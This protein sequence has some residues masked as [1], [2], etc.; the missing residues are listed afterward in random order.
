MTKYEIRTKL[1]HRVQTVRHVLDLFEYRIETEKLSIILK[2]R[3]R[4]NARE[5]TL[6]EK[7]SV[8]SPPLLR[9]AHPTEELDDAFVQI[10]AFDVAI[11]VDP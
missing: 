5:D 2:I 11:V 7:T 1:A 9:R 8:S 3:S 4:L 6:Y 10:L